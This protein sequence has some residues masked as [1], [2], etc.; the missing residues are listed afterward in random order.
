MG[1]LKL[2]NKEND[3]YWLI[4]GSTTAIHTADAPD[5]L[6]RFCPTC[7][8]LRQEMAKGFPPG[9]VPGCASDLP[10]C[11]TSRF[12]DGDTLQWGRMTVGR[13]LSAMVLI[14][15]GPTDKVRFVIEV[16]PR[17][18]PFSEDDPT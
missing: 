9:V 17:Y 5:I 4:I 3:V 12:Q 16:S 14:A 18:V 2:A 13:D 8:E 6:R 11:A 15:L 1:S 7:G 10:G